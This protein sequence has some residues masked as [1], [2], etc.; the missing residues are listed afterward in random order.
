MHI[1]DTSGGRY[2][3]LGPAVPRKTPHDRPAR[4]R[5]EPA[6]PPVAHP[7]TINAVHHTTTKA[8]RSASGN[9]HS[10]RSNPSPGPPR[11]HP[12]VPPPPRQPTDDDSRTGRDDA[13]PP[14]A[15]PTPTRGRTQSPSRYY[16][17]AQRLLLPLVSPQ[18]PAMRGEKGRRGPDYRP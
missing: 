8:T 11:Q 16:R 3:H 9:Q 18:P 1:T 13:Q 17:L 2:E 4:P 12:R 15:G 6:L 10:P 14:H 5:R 7:S